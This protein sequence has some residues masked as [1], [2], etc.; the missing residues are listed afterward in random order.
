MQNPWENII[1]D[2]EVSEKAEIRKYFGKCSVNFV[3]ILK[4]YVIK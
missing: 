2:Y 3:I 1:K 4:S